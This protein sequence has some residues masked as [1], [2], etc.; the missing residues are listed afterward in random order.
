MSDLLKLLSFIKRTNKKYV[1]YRYRRH[2][3]YWFLGYYG[4]YL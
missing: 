4:I 2:I 3:F 1:S